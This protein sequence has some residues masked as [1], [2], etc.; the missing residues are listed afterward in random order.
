MSDAILAIGPPIFH[1]Y[2]YGATTSV[3]WQLEAFR[4]S[5]VHNEEFW[6]ASGLYG[7]LDVGVSIYKREII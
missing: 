4:I 5:G 2:T 6:G 7:V 1:S 3:I